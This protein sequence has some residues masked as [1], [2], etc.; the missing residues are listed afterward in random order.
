MIQILT[1]L[2]FRT[3]QDNGGAGS[4][5]ATEK[6]HTVTSLEPKFHLKFGSD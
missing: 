1:I 2:K 4:T 6:T 3:E 5:K